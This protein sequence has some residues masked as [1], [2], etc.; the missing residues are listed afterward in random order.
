VSLAL[1][2]LEERLADVVSG[3]LQI[4]A[5]AAQVILVR[6]VGRKRE[7]WHPRGALTKG[8]RGASE[9]WRSGRDLPLE[10]LG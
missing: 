4:G 10:T 2:K 7:L 8:S 5:V 6:C 1:K 3:P 9:G